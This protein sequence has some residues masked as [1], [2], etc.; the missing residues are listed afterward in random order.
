MW[1]GVRGEETEGYEIRGLLHL[2][3]LETETPDIMHMLSGATPGT[4]RVLNLLGYIQSLVRCLPADVRKGVEEW[5]I[6][7]KGAVQDR[8][9]VNKFL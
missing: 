5:Q 9:N 4:E 1:R 6:V 7:V 8:G 2:R 3:T